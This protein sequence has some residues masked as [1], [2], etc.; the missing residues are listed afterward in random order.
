MSDELLEF[1]KLG[2]NL[3]PN[4]ALEPDDPLYV[5]TAH[6]RGEFSFHDLYQELG[7]D[8]NT[9]RVVKVPNRRYLLFT[10]HI[11]CGKS[12]EMRR[13]QSTLHNP[14]GY[15][16]ILLDARN[17]LDP[18]NLQYVDL[19]LTCAQRLCSA[20]QEKQLI[21]DAVYLD[22][23]HVWF[24]QHVITRM[25][26]KTLSTELATEIKAG[27]S[28]PFISDFLVKVT[29]AFRYNASY[30]DELREVV[31]NSFAEFAEAFNAL[32]DEANRLLQESHLG[33]GL[34]FIIDGTDKLNGKD[35]HR[36]FIED[37]HQLQ[38]IRANFLYGAPI[39]ILFETNALQQQYSAV[40][41]LPMIKL[42]NRDGSFSDNDARATLREMVLRRVP[43]QWFDGM[44]TVDHLIDHCGGHPRDLVRLLSLTW[45]KSRHNRLDRTAADKAVASMASDFRRLL[46]AR[47][48]ELMR[49]IDT[50]DDV[51]P[52]RPELTKLFKVLA[53]LEYN[54][55]WW[56]SHPIVQTLP[57]YTRHAP[58]G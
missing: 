6:A 33:R 9:S 34:L 10:G 36:F 12:T 39:H 30:K 11:G 20:L 43:L 42:Y 54:D 50:G 24:T 45:Q 26:D 46:E 41:R 17:E 21:V 28:L 4:R 15:H 7:V 14:D 23:L 16:V 31:R 5:D 18:Q 2:D 48:Y 29:N 51:Q 57:G 32:I 22:R 53:L 44:E 58:L 37:V 3:E 8:P 52:D 1:F 47:D 13:L 35:T 38:Q 19:L 49:M 27:L 56:R 55:H 25:T 40:C